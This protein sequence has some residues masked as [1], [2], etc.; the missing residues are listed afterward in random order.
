MEKA[1]RPFGKRDK[2]SYALG[3]FGCNMS[4]ALFSYLELFYTQYIG[5]D[6]KIWAIIL[7]FL[8]I[9]DGI[10]DPIMGG[11]MDAIKPGKKGKFKTYIF[12]GSFVLAVA[13][14]M[15]FLPIPN[16]PL[17]VKIIVC[18]LGY[19][20]WD[21][22]YT[23]VNVPYGAMSAAITADSGERASLSTWRS[24][25]A[26]IANVIIMVGI[27]LVCMDKDDNLIGMNV[28]IMSIVLGLIG[29]VAFQILVK[30]T[31][32]RVQI[33]TPSEEKP[34]FNYF[35][36]VGAFLKNRSA[37]GVTLA[38]IFC[39]VTMNGL[40]T[41]N[42][43]LFQSFFEMAQLSGLISL[44]SYLPLVGGMALIHP[45]VKKYGKKAVAT[46]PTIFGIVAGIL[47]AT[48]PIKPNTFG[49]IIWII[50]SMMNGIATAMFSVICWAMVSD[51]IDYQEYKTGRREEGTVYAIYSLGRKL[52]QGFGPATITL[53]M[54]GLGYNNKLKADQPFEVANNI[55]VMIGCVHAVCALLQ[56]L[57][58]KFIYNLDKKKVAEMESYFGRVPTANVVGNLELAECASSDVSNE[59][60][61]DDITNIE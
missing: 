4:F 10:N 48:L 11:L 36:A 52:A 50:L 39:L 60:I 13:G 47:M 34:K 55:R 2:I 30:G 58:L 40:A 16:A 54:V 33:E 57:F 46:Y 9:W 61:D 44:V 17:A 12:Y 21:T 35:K 59:K 56:F 7:I 41:A 27:P 14:V 38:S 5:L 26:G 3:D 23:V 15:C 25:G 1:V 51:C 29:F 20:A 8:K 24:I 19:L 43:I 22:A 18:I 32:E 42:Q 53:I 31:T 6:P 37:V 49:L 28:F 45:M